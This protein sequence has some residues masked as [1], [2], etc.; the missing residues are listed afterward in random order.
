MQ[1]TISQLGA[2]AG[3]GSALLLT[4]RMFRPT[5]HPLVITHEIIVSK[6]PGIAE[7]L[8]QLAH[9]GGQEHLDAIMEIIE[10]IIKLVKLPNRAS[11]WHIARLN[12]ET[13]RKC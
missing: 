11:Q 12:G 9:I 6:E 3:I 4:K 2:L 8:S 13:I 1:T 7:V 5:L 10:E